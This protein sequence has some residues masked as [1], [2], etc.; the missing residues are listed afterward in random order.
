[1]SKE[2]IFNNCA[3]VMML[4]YSEENFKI[5]YSHLHDTIMVSMEKYKEQE[6]GKLKRQIETIIENNLF[7]SHVKEQ[8]D[9]LL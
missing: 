8:L 3:T 2:K 1:M 6:V 5:D 7:D 4:Q 9:K